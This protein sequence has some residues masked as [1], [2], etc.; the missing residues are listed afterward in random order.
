MIFYLIGSATYGA[1]LGMALT[2]ENFASEAIFLVG[3]LA[4][5]IATWDLI[6]NP[7]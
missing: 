7:E 2:A 1:C 3:F 4:S 5:W 6:L